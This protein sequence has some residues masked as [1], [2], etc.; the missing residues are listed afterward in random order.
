MAPSVPQPQPCEYKGNWRGN[1]GGTRDQGEEAGA[2]EEV[3][4]RGRTG[5][6]TRLHDDGGAWLRHRETQTQD[7]GGV[8]ERVAEDNNLP[9]R[10]L[11]S[12]SWILALFQLPA[13]SRC[14]H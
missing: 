9:R 10:P 5:S 2:D 11:E 1:P 7:R 14:R 4:V 3:W 8:R 12:E 6:P 13:K